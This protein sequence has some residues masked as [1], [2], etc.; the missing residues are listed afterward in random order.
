MVLKLGHLFDG[1]EQVEIQQN[2]QALA[3]GSSA[4]H[5]VSGLQSSAR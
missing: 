5:K 2:D 4:G 3:G 1:K